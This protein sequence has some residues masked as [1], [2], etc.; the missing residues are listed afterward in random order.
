MSEYPALLHGYALFYL[1]R[2]LC[3]MFI[4]HVF[5]IQLVFTNFLAGFYED[6]T[7]RLHNKYVAVTL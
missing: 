6:I 1:E 4:L 3:C 2:G 5:C 7:N